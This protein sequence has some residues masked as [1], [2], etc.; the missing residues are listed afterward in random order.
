MAIIFPTTSITA[1]GS[2]NVNIP[3]SI[4]QTVDNQATVSTTCDTS[5]WVQV[6]STSITVASA[7]NQVMIE[8]F[9]NDRSDQGNGN[10]CLVY[11]RVLRDG[12]Q[13][14]YSG[15]NGAQ[16]NYIGYY[17][18]S[19]LDTPGAGA[20]TYVGQVLSYGGTAWIGNY[21]SGST[22]HYLRLYEIGR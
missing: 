20:H 9:M 11:H 3:G 18:R 14:M 6:F 19:F 4:I 7:S 10:W 8:Y 16:A 21:N 17:A 15:F 1:A 12:T 5:A 13:I 22:N 2:N